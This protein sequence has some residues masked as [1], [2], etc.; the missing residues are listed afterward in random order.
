LL[1]QAT[2]APAGQKSSDKII[3]SPFRYPGG[4]F[5]ALK[6]IMPFVDAVE[7]DEYREPFVG[8]G[9][10]F[11]GKKNV[12]FNWLND[13][14][15]DLMG[16]YRVIADPDLRVQ[17]AERLGKEKASPVRHSEVKN[18][19][20]D[21]PLE[22]AFRTYYLNRTSFSGI[23]H[24]P[25]WGYKIGQ[26][27]EPPG[28]PKKVIEAGRK[29]ESV[30]L[31]NLDFEEV[32]NAPPQGKKVFLYIDPPYYAS[33]QKRAYEKSFTKHDHERVR[34]VLKNTAYPFCLSYDDCDE[35]RN[36]YSWANIFSRQWWYN[37]ANVRASS[38]KKGRELIITN[39]EVKG[40]QMRVY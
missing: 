21:S 29:L 17:L 28:W 22:R 4:K 13:L 14:E 33:D 38:R 24:K 35:V 32:V 34:K 9:A 6:F 30:K 26:S 40:R 11:F 16:C 10:V 12:R 5:Y 15:H 7:H 1:E 20:P 2:L 8:G 3:D 25:A 27:V 19:N 37:T 18:L 36:M 39:Y 31:T 23:L